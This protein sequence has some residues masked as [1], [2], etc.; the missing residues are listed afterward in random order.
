MKHLLAIL[1]G[2]VSLT[3]CAQWNL[4]SNHS[5]HEYALSVVNRDTIVVVGFGNTFHLTTNGGQQWSLSQTMFTQSWFMDVHFPTETVGY[6]CGGSAFGLH[7]EVIV[8]TTNGGETWDSLTANAFGWFVF[9]MIHFLNED[10]GFVAREVESI[11][12]TTDGGM[13]FTI[14]PTD[15]IV[16]AIHFTEDQVGF[17]STRK[18]LGSS[19]DYTYTIQR[20]TD[21]GDTWLTVYSD[22]MQGV[23]GSDHRR[24]N[25][26]QFVND[27]VGF[28]VGGNGLFLRTIDGGDTWSHSF[29]HPFS[30]LTAL[31]FTSLSTGYINNA[32]G[33][34]KTRDGGTTWTVQKISP[35]AIIN[36]I[37][38]ANDTIGFATSVDGVY[39]TVNGGEVLGMDLVTSAGFSVYP[40]PTD[41]LL[42]LQGAD[43]IESVT[44]YNSFGQP[45]RSIGGRINRLDISDLPS[46]LYT[47][48]IETA[49]ARSCCKV[50]KM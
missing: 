38:F 32:G 7:K 20:T 28:A 18:A 11:L 12:R 24:V 25:R 40:N 50:V 45:L 42:L 49:V 1:S 22:T 36:G 47:V 46:G 4:I 10:T 8:K 33:I 37:A 23:S 31:H 26:I 39:K 41:G 9:T 16:D 30:E 6:A 48:C 35:P 5:D 17:I 44:L 19:Y 21:L 34:Y 27:L 15:G 14:L 3:A 43:L 2:I 29:V 13:S